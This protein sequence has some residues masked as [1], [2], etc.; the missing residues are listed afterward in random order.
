MAKNPDMEYFRKPPRKDATDQSRV[1]KLYRDPAA[2]FTN[3]PMPIKPGMNV[4]LP[5]GKPQLKGK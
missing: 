2:I 3:K 5:V 1:E 4:K